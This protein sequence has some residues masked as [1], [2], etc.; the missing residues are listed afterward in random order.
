MPMRYVLPLLALGCSFP[1]VP[2]P[3]GPPVLEQVDAA[4]PEVGQDAQ[5]QE[6]PDRAPDASPDAAAG[7][8]DAAEVPAEHPP[9]IKPE[10]SPDAGPTSACAASADDGG[11]RQWCTC[12]PSCGGKF[13]PYC[14]DRCDAGC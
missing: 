7:P 6:M 14:A 9:D 11:C 5:G 4:G 12:S 13:V 10:A 1:D 3:T 2:R 8:P